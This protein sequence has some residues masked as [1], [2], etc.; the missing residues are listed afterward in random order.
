MGRGGTGT[1]GFEAMEVVEGRRKGEGRD[2][3]GWRHR[4]TGDFLDLDGMY[5]PAE[6]QTGGPLRDL[7]VVE[8]RPSTQRVVRRGS[9]WPVCRPSSSV[10]PAVV[11][12]RGCCGTFWP[13]SS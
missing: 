13:V 9:T 6:A 11:R 4:N 10:I 2:V 8:V 3:G 12:W 5:R 1:L 7:L